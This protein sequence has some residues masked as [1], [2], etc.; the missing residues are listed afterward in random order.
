MD[1]II[2]IMVGSG[3]SLLTGLLAFLLKNAFLQIRNLK[4]NMYTKEE[5]RQ[6]IEDKMGPINSDLE[7]I[8]S[9]IDKLFDLF[10]NNK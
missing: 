8:K 5:V 6:L 9:K 3:A 4:E 2:L 1:Q 10:L 7:Y